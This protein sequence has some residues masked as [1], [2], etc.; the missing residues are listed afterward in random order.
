LNRK[1]RRGESDGQGGI[2]GRRRALE[3]ERDTP[4]VA[5][6][7]FRGGKKKGREKKSQVKKKK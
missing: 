5:W 6:A 2:I 7:E 1:K 4:F 3:R